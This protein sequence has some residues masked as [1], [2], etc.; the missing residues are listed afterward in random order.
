MIKMRTIKFRA[1]ADGQ[2]WY[3]EKNQWWFFSDTRYW[4]LNTEDDEVL[5][6]SL[7]S[8]NPC[9]MQFTGLYDDHGKEIYEGDIVAIRFIGGDEG[10]N[11]FKQD[12]VKW[13][14]YDIG[15][16]CGEYG[17]EVVGP[18]VEDEF[19]YGEMIVGRVEV[20]GNIHEDSP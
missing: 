19:L 17:F 12:H 9:L 13:G 3:P 16:N 14:V 15:V 2:M 6:D 20:V 8:A 18:Y 10:G 4:S 1:W 11:V 5:C 7:E